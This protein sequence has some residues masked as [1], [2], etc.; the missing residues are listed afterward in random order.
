VV[1]ITAPGSGSSFAA[2]TAIT[3]TG[4]AT[5]AEDGNISASI[6]WSSSINGTFGT[7]ASVTTSSLSAGTHTITASAT[8]SGSLTGS[9]AISVTVTGGTTTVTFTSTGSQD[10]RIFESTENAE[11][12]GGFNST[13]TGT[14]AIRVGDWSDDTQYRSIVSFNTASIPDGATIVSATLRLRRG[15]SSGTN[16]FTTHGTCTVDVATGFFGTGV[17]MAAADWQAA[18]TAS[19]VAAMSNPTTNGTL[20]SGTLNAAGRAAISKTGTTQFRIYMTLG[21]N[22]DLGID[23]IGFYPGENGT[24][25]NRPQL[26]VTYQ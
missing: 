8:D 9:D 14:A 23:Y 25:S 7:G 1:D 3:F 22:D 2:G 20:S 10:G 17:T 18:A 13:D 15:T 5:D 21:D 4:T 11:V 26:E 19:G 24:A 16:P 12:G 6:T